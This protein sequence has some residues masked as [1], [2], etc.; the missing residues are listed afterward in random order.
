MSTS[1]RSEKD[2][3]R[4][5]LS[6][7][8]FF[9][10]V[11]FLGWVH[12]DAGEP[13]EESPRRKG[14]VIGLVPEQNVF[15]QIERYTPMANYLSGRAGVRTRLK[16]LTHYGNSVDDLISSEL[17]GAFFGSLTYVLARMKIGVEPLVRPENGDGSSTYHG[18][19]FVRTDSGI[20]NAKDMERKRFALVDRATTAGFLLPMA[21][22]RGHGI[23]NYRTYLK[24]AYFT[25]THED[26]IYDVLN[27]KAE[28]GAAKSTVFDRLAASDKRIG[29]ELKVLARSPDVPETT[30]ALRKDIDPS[31]RLSLLEALLNMHQDPA[32][33]IVL[34]NFGARRFIQ[35]VDKEYDVV[36]SY[37]AKIGL[38]LEEFDFAD[39]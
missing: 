15:K 33:Q 16:I 36:R 27:K 28:I 32:G 21:Y 1:T 35:T 34:K 11:G 30:L 23:E 22:F 18:L 20:K 26:A 10:L 12:S 13:G 3:L 14:L 4:R 31:L 2:V 19:I 9:C 8:L 24:E 38:K 25:G 37:G 17:D 5:W 7:F 29:T 6:A 39:H